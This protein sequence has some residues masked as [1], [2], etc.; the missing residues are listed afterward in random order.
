MPKTLIENLRAQKSIEEY[1]RQ[2]Y[3]KAVKLFTAEDTEFL[4]Q[5]IEDEKKHSKIVDEVV[6][7][8]KTAKLAPPKKSAFD[9]KAGFYFKGFG[10]EFSKVLCIVSTKNYISARKALAKYIVNLLGKKCLY[11]NTTSLS[12]RVKKSLFV[13]GVDT[14]KLSFLEC[15]FSASSPEDCASLKDLTK[16]TVK[17][18]KALEKSDFI[19]FDSLPVLKIYH[20]QA[21]IEKFMHFLNSHTEKKGKAIVW[22]GIKENAEDLLNK[23]AAMLCE[24][25]VD[26]SNF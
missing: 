24:K 7:I 13:G 17:I 5:I 12:K 26:L 2:A 4:R 6:S 8:V 11:I 22:I 3:S 10:K 15:A 1:A 23:K 19:I 9:Q 16:L 18:V 21:T 25:T 20:D 14:A